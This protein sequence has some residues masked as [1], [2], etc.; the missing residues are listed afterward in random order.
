MAN[1]FGP[2]ELYLNQAGKGF[3]SIRGPLVGQLGHD[4]YKGM[5]ASIGDLDNNGYPDIYVS[6]VHEPLQAEGS[7][8]WMNAGQWSTPD[9]N[10]LR[11]E[12]MSRNALN[13]RRFGWGGTFGD[14]NLDGRLDIVQANGHIDDAYDDRYEDC[15]DYWYWNEK[16]ALTSPDVHGYA[17]SWA[18]LR[19]RCVF[20]HEPDRIYLN[21]GQNFVDVASQVGLTKAIPSRGVA[22]ADLDNDGDLDILISHQFAPLSIYRNE[23]QEQSWIGFKLIGNGTTCNRDALGTKLKLDLPSSEFSSQYREV[24]ASNGFSSQNDPRV[25]FGLGTWKGL[26]QVTIDWC[27]LGE[28]QTITRKDGKYYELRN[29]G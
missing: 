15:P 23:T 27:G 28:L 22:L 14:L 4:T 26:V 7:L 18:D 25:L 20:P 10:S 13:E 1:D 19:G 5:N 16:I 17:D 2:D 11:D 6:N 8:L 24:V 12:A 9:H 29:E 21:Q 3:M